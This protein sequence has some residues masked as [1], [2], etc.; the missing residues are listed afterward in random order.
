MGLRQ[1]TKKSF[2]RFQEVFSNYK[3]LDKIKGAYTKMSEDSLIIMYNEINNALIDYDFALIA[4]G[5][6]YWGEKED[7]MMIK[8]LESKL[9]T[10]LIVFSIKKKG[11]PYKFENSKWKNKWANKK[12]F[13][14]LAQIAN[15][16]DKSNVDL[17]Y[18]NI[19]VEGGFEN[20]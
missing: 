16:K 15:F 2:T 19:F 7:N 13:D 9:M 6:N 1:D 17:I 18:R 12:Y 4:S 3:E 8:Y 11:L 20:W 10:S 14:E 5:R